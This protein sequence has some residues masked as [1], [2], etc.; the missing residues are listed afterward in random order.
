MPKQV[1]NFG[2]S[3]EISPNLV[4]LVMRD[5][6]S[7]R[8]GGR[9]R[10]WL[11][12]NGSSSSAHVNGTKGGLREIVMLM[13]SCHVMLISHSKKCLSN[14]PF[15]AS[16]SLIFIVSLQTNITI[17]TT[18]KCENMFIQYSVLGFKPTT[19]RTLDASHNHWTRAPA[20]I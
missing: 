10:F 13:M 9:E 20:Q 19:F 1:Q 16:F 6:M 8:K 14:W 18:N 3:G 4:T 15:T 5:R 2:Q 7:R 12:Q 17:F 11:S